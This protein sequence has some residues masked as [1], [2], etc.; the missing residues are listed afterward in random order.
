MEKKS[1]PKKSAMDAA[2][3]YLGIRDRSVGEMREYL[4]K[5]QYEP[6]EIGS[7]LSRLEELR[8]LDDSAFARNLLR[9]KTTMKPLSRMEM[10]SVLIRHKIG[11]QTAEETLSEFDGGMELDAALKLAAEVKKKVAKYPPE[12]RWRRAASKMAA[13][14]FPYGVI[15][16]ALKDM[17]GEDGDVSD[18]MDE[19]YTE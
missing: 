3:F 9:S 15:R 16:E 6:E 12:E 5:K 8:L 17:T 14:G 2:L 7:V 13:K 4:Q 1:S 19:E 18:G 10:R 11:K